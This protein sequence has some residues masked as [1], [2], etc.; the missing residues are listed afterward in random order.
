MRCVRWSAGWSSV[1]VGLWESEKR[2]SGSP[3]LLP[4]SLTYVRL[5]PWGFAQRSFE[6]I[7]TLK[8]WGWK[9]TGLV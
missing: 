2:L 3:A 8:R 9:T 1:R 7:A 4:A 6:K 5:L